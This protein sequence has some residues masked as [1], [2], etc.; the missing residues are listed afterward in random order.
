[1]QG[2]EPKGSW[3]SNPGYPSLLKA[4]Q[5]KVS[6]LSRPKA[7][8]QCQW[9]SGRAESSCKVINFNKRKIRKND[10]EVV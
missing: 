9:W 3:P 1:M 8:W 4:Y 7:K 10:D 5:K 6:F 2:E